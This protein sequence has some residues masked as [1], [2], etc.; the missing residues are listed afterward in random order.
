MVLPTEE[1]ADLVASAD[2]PRVFLDPGIRRGWRLS[3]GVV[4]RLLHCGVLSLSLRH[5]CDVGIFAVPKKSA[6]QRLVV[7]ARARS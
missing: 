6:K 1:A 2:A 7:D 3:L 4:R 5:R